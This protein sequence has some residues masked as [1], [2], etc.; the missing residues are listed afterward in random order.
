MPLTQPLEIKLGVYVD[1]V[2]K[3]YEVKYLGNSTLFSS[4]LL[5][6]CSI[7]FKNKGF[8]V[9]KIFRINKK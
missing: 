2:V 1:I 5:F 4:F 6:I 3:Q 7:Y 8:F 9:L